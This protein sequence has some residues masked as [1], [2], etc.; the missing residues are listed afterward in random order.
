MKKKNKIFLK[1]RFTYLLARLL[2]KPSH[3]SV[4]N[5][6]KRTHKP[7]IAFPALDHSSLH[8]LVRT[9]K[10]KVAGNWEETMPFNMRLRVIMGAKENLRVRE[11]R[12][13]ERSEEER[14]GREK[15]KCAEEIIR[16]A[17]KR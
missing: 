13:R 10:W 11:R 14:D 7:T 8:Y 5:N 4:D 1:C 3:S 16:G 9:S 6:K 2:T 15:K 17:R 12:A